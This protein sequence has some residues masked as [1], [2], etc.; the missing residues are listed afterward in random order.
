MSA[1][2]NET[3]IMIQ[4]TAVF[5]HQGKR[6]QFAP[7]GFNYMQAKMPHEAWTSDGVVIFIAVDGAWDV[8]WIGDPPS[9]TIWTRPLRQAQSKEANARRAP[10]RRDPYFDTIFRSRLGPC[11]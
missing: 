6:E 10:R 8:N 3:H 4:G 11:G 5:D 2:G 7:R 9:K 1:A